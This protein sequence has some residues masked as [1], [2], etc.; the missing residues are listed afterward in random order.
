MKELAIEIMRIGFPM[1]N[2]IL[3]MLNKKHAH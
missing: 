2:Q 3:T 1:K